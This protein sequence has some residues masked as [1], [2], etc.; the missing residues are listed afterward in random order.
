MSFALHESDAFKR[1]KKACDAY[2]SLQDKYTPK[3]AAMGVYL[4]YRLNGDDETMGTVF[5]LSYTAE[6]AIDSGTPGS[7]GEAVRGT[8]GTKIGKG[9]IPYD[10]ITKVAKLQGGGHS[11]EIFIR[12]ISKIFSDP[13][14]MGKP[15]SKVEMFI[16]KI[17]CCKFENIGSSAFAIGN[18]I[19]PEGCGAKLQILV[20]KF[21]AIEW[22]FCFEKD[23]ADNIEVDKITKSKM[24]Q[25]SSEK[26]VKVYR[27]GTGGVI[28]EFISGL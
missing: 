16:S 21:P 1:E 23:Y 17:P 22:A 24:A 20:N 25:L 13:T 7:Y 26:N 27:Y 15:V 2:Q 18:D 8:S 6:P 10:T 9:K 4:I 14:L 11:E 28:T 12:S 19:F 5:S 3:Q